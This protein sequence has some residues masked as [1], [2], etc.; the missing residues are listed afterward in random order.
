M[1]QIYLYQNSLNKNEVDVIDTD[2]ILFEFLK[3]KTI[4][5]SKI[6]LGNPC[7]ENDIT[8]SIK[9]KAS[10]ARL[11]EIAD[12]CSIVCH[13]GELSSFVTWV[14]TKILGSAVSALV[15]VPK[16]NMSN[17]GS[18]S[19]SSN[20]NLSDPE[21]RQR[22]K[23]RIPFILGRVKAIPDLLLQSSNT[24]KMGSKLKNL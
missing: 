11:T 5:S 18:M 7:P 3:V 23:Q 20:N 22:L 17:N 24:L 19:G 10:I 21:N 2:N 9:D 8:P 15:K 14:A 16:P 4:S 1:S 13:P 6:Y 12:D